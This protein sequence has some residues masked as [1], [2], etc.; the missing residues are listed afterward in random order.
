MTR[1]DGRWR[2]PRL[3]DLSLSR[4]LYTELIAEQGFDP[5]LPKPRPRPHPSRGVLIPGAA[6]DR[7]SR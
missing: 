7:L 2:R 4:D 6:L 1:A 3:A 5:Q